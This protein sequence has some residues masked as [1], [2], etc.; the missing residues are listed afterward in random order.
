MYLAYKFPEVI[1]LY[2]NSSVFKTE[3]GE[4]IPNL[5]EVIHTYSEDMAAGPISVANYLNPNA[6]LVLCISCPPRDLK[7]LINKEFTIVLS[8]LVGEN[9]SAKVPDKFFKFSDTKL[10]KDSYGEYLAK[11]NEKKPERK[12]K[13][14]ESLD[15]EDESEE[16]EGESS[17]MDNSYN[18]DGNQWAYAEHNKKDARNLRNRK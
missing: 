18:E 15:E 2:G 11:L 1:S 5:V 7:V 16:F 13:K 6:K 9:L 3:Q 14:S 17:D 12:S 8:V 10:L 4:L